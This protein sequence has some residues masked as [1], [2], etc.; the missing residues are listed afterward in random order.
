MRTGG[1]THSRAVTVRLDDEEAFFFLLALAPA[2][3]DLERFLLVLPLS[4]SAMISSSMSIV[5]DGSSGEKFPEDGIGRGSDESSG[6]F[7]SSKR[8]GARIQGVRL[9]GSS[10]VL[11]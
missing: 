11:R 5:V 2:V 4:T 10:G 8:R 7:V 1:Q 9:A 6:C 3:D